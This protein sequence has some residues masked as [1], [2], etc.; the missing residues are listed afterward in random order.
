MHPA[1]VIFCD[2]DHSNCLKCSPEID[3]S[4]LSK[5]DCSIPYTDI[6]GTRSAFTPVLLKLVPFSQDLA[7]GSENGAPQL[8]KTI[9]KACSLVRSILPS[10]F[11]FL[12]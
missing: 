7:V 10:E 1:S 2:L 6:H 5:E 3:A 8:K 4:D 12:I 11:Y 9:V